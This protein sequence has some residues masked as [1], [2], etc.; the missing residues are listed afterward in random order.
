MTEERPTPPT[1]AES[2]HAAHSS[3]KAPHPA[4]YFILF[5][6]FGATSGFIM[7]TIGAL[8]SKTGMSD[9]VVTAMTATNTLP[10]T[11]KFL[12][13]PVVDTL[14]TGRGWYITTNLIS[15]A[16]I[17]LLGFI[18]IG[19]DTVTLMTVIIF[20][21]GLSTTFIGM[22]TESLMAKLTPPEQRGAA[23]GWSQAGNLGGATI[24][25][26]GLFMAN[27]LPEKWMPFVIVGGLLLSCSVVLS[28]VKEPPRDRSITF[29]AALRA[30]FRD[31]WALLV[32]QRRADKLSTKWWAAFPPV[33]IYILSG[34]GILAIT[35]SLMPIGSGGAQNVFPLSSMLK[36]WHVS[37][38]WS[39]WANG[40]L[41]GLGSIG[42][43]LLGGLL[44][45]K[46]DKRKAY[47]VSGIILALF[48]FGMVPL[49][50]TDVYY[51][52]G[53]V[54]YSVGLGLCYATFTAF[55]LDIIGHSGGATKYNLFASLANMPIYIMGRVDGWVSTAHGRNAM[56]WIDGLAGVAGAV[57]LLGVV[58]ILRQ[59]KLDPVPAA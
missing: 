42:G 41:S 22:C 50:R 6:P 52:I 10:H 9:A 38:D 26:L 8:A 36:E 16:C 31:I 29:I 59:R 14:W 35:L 44:A 34:A 49:P 11:W 18:P 21:N 23:G 54:T 45:S 43:S 25:G 15:S 4:L 57:V 37:E 46:I 12:W 17:I 2:A 48:A 51:T 28:F 39:G 40:L 56:L 30:L 55:V 13:A 3:G 1:D 53:I 47:A 33:F 5:L 24:G 7:Y 58:W 27:H 32:D 19:P 20:I